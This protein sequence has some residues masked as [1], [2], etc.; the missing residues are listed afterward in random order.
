MMRSAVEKEQH[1]PV[2]EPRGVPA[3]SRRGERA[4]R[5]VGGSLTE[6]WRCVTPHEAARG[7]WLWLF[8]ALSIGWG[9]VN[10]RGTMALTSRPRCIK[11]RPSTPDGCYHI[12]DGWYSLPAMG[13]IW[14]LKT[15]LPF[16][17]GQAAQTPRWYRRC[18]EIQCLE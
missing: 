14:N 1:E 7:M 10:S 5:D 11:S 17:T 4:C 9:N 2:S 18:K 3:R 16:D 6:V 15:R 8:L 12:F 13:S